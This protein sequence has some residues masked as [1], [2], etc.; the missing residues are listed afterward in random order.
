MDHFFINPAKLDVVR[1]RLLDSANARS[2]LVPKAGEVWDDWEE[3]LERYGTAPRSY[4]V[5]GG[6]AIIPV[7]GALISAEIPYWFYFGD[8]S[9]EAMA[10]TVEHAVA[11]SEVERVLLQINSPGGTVTGCAAA[12]SRIDVASSGDKPVWAQCSMA[13]SAA[14]WIASATNRIIVDPTGEVGSIGVITT[15]VDM[16]KMLEEWG[17]KVTHIFSGSHKADGSPYAPLSDSAKDSIQADIDQLRTLFVDGVAAYRRMDAGA[18]R[19]TEALTFIGATAVSEGLADETGFLNEVLQTMAEHT[20]PG[21]AATATAKKEERSTMAKK[22]LSKTPTPKASQED[23]DKK[24]AKADDAAANEDEDEDETA[25]EASEDDKDEKDAK[26][27]GDGDD[28]SAERTRISAILGCKEAE[29]RAGLAQHLALKTGMSAKEAKLV[30]ATAPRE[31]AKTA[32]NPLSEAMGKNGNPQIGSDPSAPNANAVI[33]D[34]KR[35][36]PHAV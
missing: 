34:M 22:D 4:R 30:L 1:H 19:K 36:F 10:A 14:Y 3:F 18:V 28:A 24:D 16:S 7:R 15:H 8:T 35:R 32:V 27:D 5:A 26:E 23:E 9:Y 2:L 11:N 25:P 31:T 20:A 12:A 17:I 29:G 13:D 6:T 21:V 33:A